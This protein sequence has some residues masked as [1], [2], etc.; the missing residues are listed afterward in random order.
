MSVPWIELGINEVQKDKQPWR[1]R[2]FD[3]DWKIDKF[4]TWP[5]YPVKLLEEQDFIYTYCSRCGSRKVEAHMLRKKLTGFDREW[6]DPSKAAF[7]LDVPAKN[8]VDLDWI[9]TWL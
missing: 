3:H 8:R 6:L 4:K 1:C 9:G 2:W 5:S 7:I